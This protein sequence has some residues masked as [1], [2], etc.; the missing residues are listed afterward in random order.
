MGCLGGNEGTAEPQGLRELLSAHSPLD[1]ER[2]ET[3]LLTLDKQPGGKV[4]LEPMVQWAAG[5]G[6]S[7]D[8]VLV[9]EKVDYY[10]SMDE[11]QGLLNQ[12]W[13]ADVMQ[14]DQLPLPVVTEERESSTDTSP[15]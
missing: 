13:T 15:E 8:D 6:V 3:L 7:N 5:I 9:V 4:L 2:W 14:M 1:E 12:H 10:R 11:E